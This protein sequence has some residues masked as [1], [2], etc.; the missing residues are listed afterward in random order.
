VVIGN[1]LKELR[2]SKELSQ[3]D[4]VSGVLDGAA[5][6]SLALTTIRVCAEKRAGMEN[7]PLSN[8]RN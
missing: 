4:I 7:P 5:L 8:G 6:L 2:E 1:R 3:G